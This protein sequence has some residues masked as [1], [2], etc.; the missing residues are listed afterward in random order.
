[1]FVL[2]TPQITI[3]EDVKKP[4]FG[5]N[6]K[7][8]LEYQAILVNVA[9]RIKQILKKFDPNKKE[10]S[11]MVIQELRE[12][13]SDLY[14][15]AGNRASKIIYSLK[16]D[17][18]II[19]KQHSAIIGSR[20]RQDLLKIP[21]HPIMKQFLKDNISLIQSMPI[22]A[23][24]QIQEIAV[25][26]ITTGTRA[27]AI[28]TQ[29]QRIGDVTENRARLIAR[30]EISRMGTGLIKARAEVLDMDWYVWK[31]SMDMRVRSSHSIMNNVIVNWNDEP[32]PERLVGKKNYGTYHAGCTFNCRCYP[33]PIIRV[34]DIPA[35]IKVYRNGRIQ[36]MIKSNFLKIAAKNIPIAA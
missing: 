33:E 31:T 35:H 10:T 25:E 24:R 12:Y 8:E 17:D 30:T 26:A 11:L 18:D 27:E 6:K 4:S 15:W 5:Y 21:L 2:S 13:S 34:E 14:N 1:M 29:I 22:K 3:T 19:W 7:L 9:K 28:I 36:S 16:K 23:A 20:L 32:S